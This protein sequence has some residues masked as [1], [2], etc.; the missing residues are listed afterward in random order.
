MN[1]YKILSDNLDKPDID[2]RDYRLIQLPNKLVALLI[3]DPT[4]DKSAAALD[5]NAGAFNDPPELPGLAHFCEH[6]LFMGTEKYPSENEYGSY[7]SKNSGFSNA[8]TSS[9]HTNFYYEVA[10]PAMEGAIDRFAQFFI[11]PLF[12]PSGKDR[13]I[14]AVDSENKKNL[15]NDSWRLYQLSKSLTS[16][17]HPYHGFSTGNKVTLGE[18]PLKNGLDVREELLKYHKTH[19]SANLMRLVVLSNEKLDTLTDW[20]VDKFSSVVNKDLPKPF[21]FKSP[22]KDSCYNGTMLVKA[23]PITEMRALQ[24]SFPVPDS[25]PYWE[26][27]P[28]KYLSHL[29]GHESKGSLLYSLKEKKW[30]TSLNAGAM[31][32]SSGFSEFGIDIELT[33]QGLTHYEEII[34]EIFKY[35]KMLQVEGPQEYIYNELRDQSISAFKFRQKFGSSA[36]ASKLASTLHDLSY[37]DTSLS[38]AKMDIP[39]STRPSVAEIPVE[40]LLSLPVVRK[41]DPELISTYSSYLNPENFKSM[42]VAKESFE[43]PSDDGILH[44]KWYETEYKMENFEPKL[45]ESIKDIYYKGKNLDAAYKLPEHNSFIPTDFSLVKSSDSVE[46]HPKLIS[47]DQKRKVWYKLNTKLGGPRSSLVFKFNLP[48]ATSTPLNSLL[49]SLFIELLDDDLSSV[50]YLAA[51]AGLSQE[52]NMARDGITLEIHGY[53]HK[54]EILLERLI[55]RVIKFTDPAFTAEIW[56]EDRK[57]RFEVLREKVSKNLKNFGYSV[58]YNQVGP[59]ISSL[60]NENS[61]L[62]ADQLAV[63]EAVN[64]DTLRNFS[65]N[66]FNVCFIEVLALGN[67][68]KDQASRICDM[69]SSKFHKSITLSESQFT[70]G[71]TLDLPKSKTYNYLK[72]NDD[73]KNINSCIEVYKQIGMISSSR[74]R[75]MAELVSQIIH[76]PFFNRLR[77]KEQLGYVV[78]SGLRETR[79]TFGL[80]FLV[81]SERAT[82]YLYERIRCFVIKMG[83]VID[84]MKESEFKKHVD[85]VVTR[86][87]Q[88]VKNLR[89]ERTRFWN[90]IASGY[91]DFDRREQDVALLKSFTIGELRRYYKTHVLDESVSGKLIIH[92][93]S[94][95]IPEQSKSAIIKSSI[96]NFLFDYPEFDKLEYDQNDI[97][98]LVDQKFKDEDTDV[99]ELLDEIVQDESFTQKFASFNYANELKRYVLNELSKDYSKVK[100]GESDVIIEQTGEWK[101]GIPLTAAPSAKM[102]PEYLDRDLVDPKL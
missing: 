20:T 73:V 37:Y 5:V 44:E 40:H 60:I 87:L 93:Q 56:D 19:Y 86:K 55:D 82:P 59:M 102:L 27:L 34:Q 95:L 77:T 10:N 100:T 6:L 35:I 84:S 29:I 12:S 21:Y 3:H 39:E 79:T 62:V 50:S 53:S 9:L 88:K 49:L 76:E 46:N 22:Y 32:V 96:S 83:H 1:P 38:D 99:G 68:D 11:C 16:Q 66:L 85:A 74:D 80:R 15:E 94:Q 33:K 69:V 52:F 25:N 61:W 90:R 98:K 23:K 75:V 65:A 67:Y 97:N 17:Y 24:L 92:L 8:Y 64:F 47:A 71:R 18:V 43:G 36:T 54:L 63:Y 28:S 30:A 26:Y 42:L 45:L 7:L 89:E 51:I 31:N 14:N 81:Q 41:F 72:A 101:C 2:D 13:E 4:A 48:G 58:P 57:A 70:R 91:Y 78:F